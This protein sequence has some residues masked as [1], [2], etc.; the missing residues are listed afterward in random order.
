MNITH[1]HPAYVEAR[2]KIGLSRWNGAYYY[3]KEIVRHFI[4]TIETWRPW[5]TVQA[6][7]LAVDH[8]IYFIHHNYN[9]NVYRHLAK[10]KDLVLVCGWPQT[11]QKVAHLGKAVYLPL[12]VDVEDVAQYRRE[13]DRDICCAGRK[14]KITRAPR[15][16]VEV[17]GLPRAEFLNELARYRKV[18][19]MDRVAI[20]A[21]V[22]GCEVLPYHPWFPDPDFWRVIDSH[23]AARMLQGLL[24]DIDG[25]Q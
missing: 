2:S 20:E 19:A 21:K 23:D 6:G 16:T 1:E 3:S 9:T 22:L 4:P 5:V 14:E 24:D 12:S 25:R 17:T 13:K 11:V 7:E 10:Y 18:Y 8:A 15:G